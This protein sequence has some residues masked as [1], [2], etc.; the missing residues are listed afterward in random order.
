MKNI[1]YNNVFQIPEVKE[2]IKETNKEKYGTEYISQ[3]EYYKDKFE[4]KIIEKYGN[5][6]NYYKQ[7]YDTY[8]Q[9]CLIRYNCENYFQYEE[10][11]K[12]NFTDELIKKR[13]DSMIENGHWNFDYEKH[14]EELKN[15]TKKV[16]SLTRKVYRKYKN[17]I[18]PNNLKISRTEYNLDHKRSIYDCFYDSLTPEQCANINNLIIITSHENHTKNKK[19]SITKEELL[20]LIENNKM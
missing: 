2:Q 14:L 8:K 13:K 11:I 7:K 16:R 15:Y 1:G 6:E 10:F 19:S 20:F 3:S 9:T 5:L 17:I 4:N 18:N 12:S